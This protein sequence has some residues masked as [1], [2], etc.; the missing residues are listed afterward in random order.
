[1]TNESQSVG[2]LTVSGY[3]DRAGHSSVYGKGEVVGRRIEE[4]YV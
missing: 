4:T 3:R 1:M 2:D